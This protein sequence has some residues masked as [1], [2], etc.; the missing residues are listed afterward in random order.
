MADLDL[1]QG[2]P[3]SRTEV[4]AFLDHLRPA[5]IADGGNIELASIEADGTV[6]VEMQ[7]E[8]A[9]CPAQL[10]TLRV[11][12]EEPLQRSHPGVAAVVAI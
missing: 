2:N 7:G 4:E 12:I 9:R 5:L 10:A 1:K 8:C 3:P 6:R 11:A